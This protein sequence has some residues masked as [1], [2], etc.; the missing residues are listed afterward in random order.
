MPEILREALFSEENF[1]FVER[2]CKDN[3]LS[4]DKISSV[5]TAVGDVIFGFIHPEDLA[6]EIKESAGINILVGEEISK[7]INR[8]IFIPI[9]TD[10]D[11]VYFPVP[12][13]K[14]EGVVDLRLQE[15]P[16]AAES[17][18][19]TIEITPKET[20]KTALEVGKPQFAG[21]VKKEEPT[22]FGKIEP[23]VSG[24]TLEKSL[25]EEEAPMILHKETEL[26]PLAADKKSLAE[27]FTFSSGQEP[28]ARKESSDLAA[29]ISFGADVE[30]KK[31]NKIQMEKPNVR[32]VHYSD[33]NTPMSPFGKEKP[34]Q[35]QVFSQSKEINIGFEP[36]VVKMEEKSTPEISK[37]ESEKLFI[38]PVKTEI[39]SLTGEEKEIHV[40]L[41][42]QSSIK[43]D[44]SAKIG[45]SAPR[46]EFGLS[47]KAAAEKKA[48]EDA[49]KQMFKK[50]G[51]AHV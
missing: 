18:R 36:K 44:N 39:N 15:K 31:E 30:K 12:S 16:V 35:S 50:I 51:R 6:K 24:I 32:V 17:T 4:E 2:A 5:A 27:V 28:A 3:H 13:H 49:R 25:G 37:K 14:P 45:F 41:V 26:T 21:E 33:L 46:P 48:F 11:K 40:P 10:I 29:K 7:E 19:E 43:I 38:A 9:K 22:V 23:K 47:I 34:F 42:E 8:K 1:N 20:L